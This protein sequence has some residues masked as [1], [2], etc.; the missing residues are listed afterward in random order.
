ML[1]EV[2]TVLCLGGNTLF[3]F[4]RRAKGGDKSGVGIDALRI[5][6]YRKP[7][8]SYNFV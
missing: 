3:L 5:L 1:Y 4:C 8:K 2:I 7:W 6:R